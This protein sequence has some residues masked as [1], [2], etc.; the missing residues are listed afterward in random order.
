MTADYAVANSEDSEGITGDKDALIIAD[1]CT[2]WV[3]GY[4]L[5]SRESDDGYACFTHFLGPGLPM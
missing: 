5:P 1:R 4:P 2:D 3:Y